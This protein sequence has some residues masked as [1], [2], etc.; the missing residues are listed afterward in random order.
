MGV[1]LLAPLLSPTFISQRFLQRVERLARFRLDGSKF[2]GVG[3]SEELMRMDLHKLTSWEAAAQSEYFEDF[4]R[5]LQF[6]PTTA[7][8]EWWGDIFRRVTK[9]TGPLVV[10]SPEELKAN[11]VAGRGGKSTG[12]GGSYGG[13]GSS[14]GGR[15]S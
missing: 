14:L 8:L 10:L 5:T 13:R 3:E 4:S 11:K 7:T 15:S 9:H 6:S 12:G 1:L 2:V